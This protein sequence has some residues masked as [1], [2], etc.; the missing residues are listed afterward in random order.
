MSLFQL[1]IY[2]LVHY[3][4]PLFLSPTVPY[5]VDIAVVTM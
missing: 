3:D 5:Q 4:P 2:G 1:S